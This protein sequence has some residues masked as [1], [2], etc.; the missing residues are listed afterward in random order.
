MPYLSG[1]DCAIILV[2][3]IWHSFSILQMEY[4]SVT[5]KSSENELPTKVEK[6]LHICVWPCVHKQYSSLNEIS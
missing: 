4:K 2:F 1:F 3:R 6:K 5:L